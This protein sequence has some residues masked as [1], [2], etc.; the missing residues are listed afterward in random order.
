MNMCLF[1][2]EELN[3]PLAKHDARAQHLLKVLHKKVGDAFSAGVIGSKSGSALITNIENGSISYRF[4]E[5]G[6][7]KP[8]VPLCMIIG[9]PRPIQLKR[10]LRD[11][12]IL[13]VSEIHLTGTEN[14]E[15]SYMQ[16][17]VVTDGTAARMLLDGAVQA[18]STHLPALSVHADVRQCLAALG[19]PAGEVRIA[20]DNVNPDSN[21]K[22]VLAG[23][24]GAERIYA[25]IGSER[26]WTDN[27][28]RLL[29]ERRFIR[30]GME[31]RILRTETAATAAAAIIASSMD[32]M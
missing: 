11:L 6:D 2:P 8:L 13:G 20:L 15:K 1:T 29:E 23:A 30:T 31:A 28:R 9:F 18:G 16:S 5:G 19:M 32:W 10:L 3:L 27:E 22:T 25:A 12:S 21:L 17:T 24:S 14:G 26:G 4:S 7:N